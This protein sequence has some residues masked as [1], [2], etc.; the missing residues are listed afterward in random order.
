MPSDIL[1]EWLDKTRLGLVDIPSDDP[2]WEIA[3]EIIKACA[4]KMG[5]TLDRSTLRVMAFTIAASQTLQMTLTE[6][7]PGDPD[8]GDAVVATLGLLSGCIVRTLGDG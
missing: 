5:L 4:E 6:A 2:T 1:D 3:T 8:F 7:E